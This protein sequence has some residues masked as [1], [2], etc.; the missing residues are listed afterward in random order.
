[1]TVKVVVGAQYGGEGKGKICAHL[2]LTDDIDIMVRCGGPNSGH[3]VD[4]AGERYELKQVPAGFVNPRTLLFIAAG[5]LVNPKL[6]LEEV[7]L[8]GL[9]PD[10]MR[11]DRNAMVVEQTHIETE[12]EGDLRERLSSTMQGV[13]AAVSMRTARAPGV[14]LA[15]HVPELQPFITSVRDELS[16]AE[17]EGKSILVEGTQGFGLSLY[18]AEEWPYCT[19]RDTTAHSFLG[20]VGVGVRDYSVIM[21]VRTFPI[22]VGGNSGPLANEITWEKLQGISGYPHPISELTTTTKRLRRVAQFDDDVV[23][24]AVAANFP[25]ALALHG[26]DYLDHNNK[27]LNSFKELTPATQ[28]WVHKLERTTG[29]PVWFVGSGP[30]VAELVDRRELPAET[31]EAGTKLRLNEKQSSSFALRL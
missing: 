31:S 21:C 1:M 22:R 23:D 11:I 18:H 29:V 14:R 3:T 15:Q 19:S 9:T 10:R 5:G 25:T 7:S 27:G 26:A 12:A 17:R 30:T 4:L 16:S 8:C 2:A 28:K 13:G 24:R 6:F 20:E